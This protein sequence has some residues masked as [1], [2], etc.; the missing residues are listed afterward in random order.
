MVLDGCHLIRLKLS[1]IIHQGENQQTA[2]LVMK[3]AVEVAECMLK[4]LRDPKMATSSYVPST[5]G[6]FSWGETIEK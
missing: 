4:E 1:Y 2:D 3:M 5:N 6:V